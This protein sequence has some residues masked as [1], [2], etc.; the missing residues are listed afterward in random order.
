VNVRDRVRGMQ[1]FVHEFLASPWI[2][3]VVLGVR[4]VLVAQFASWTR[5]PVIIFAGGNRPG[6]AGVPCCFLLATPHHM[7]V[8]S[9]VWAWVMM[10][11]KSWCRNSIFDS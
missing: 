4:W 2:L 10:L 5:I 1:S 6:L 8:M 11:G 9:A 3:S 7:N